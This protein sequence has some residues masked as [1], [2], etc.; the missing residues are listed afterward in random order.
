MK[1]RQR[2]GDRQRTDIQKTDRNKDS[3]RQRYR[4]TDG[5]ILQ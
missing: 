3:D 2:E 1:Q 5:Q 4:Q